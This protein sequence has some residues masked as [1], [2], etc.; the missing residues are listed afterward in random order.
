MVKQPQQQAPMPGQFFD[1]PGVPGGSTQWTEQDETTTN[2]LTTLQSGTQQTVQGILSF[3]QTDVV[4]DW[5]VALNIAQ[6][7][8]P[9]TSALAASAYAPF[10]VIG[11]VQLVIQNQYASV[12]VESGIDLYIFNI[13]RPHNLGEI[14]SGVNMG[15]NPGGFPVGGTALG[16]RAAA[17]AQ[18][19]NIPNNGTAAVWASTSTQ[20]NLLLRLPA[21]QWF[22]IY[23]DLLLTGEPNTAAHAALVSPQYMA[24]TTRNITPKITF[25]PGNAATLDQGPVNIGAGTGTYAGTAT[26]RFRRRAIYAGNE[27][28]QPPVYAW[29]YRW[30]TTRFGIGGKSKVDLPLPLDTGQLLLCYVRLFDPAAAAALG[31]PIALSTL[32]RINLQYGAGLFW[33]DAGNDGAITPAELIQRKWLSN[34][35]VMLPPGVWAFDLALDER[36]Q[37]SNKRALNTLTTAGILAH[38]DS[39]APVSSTSYATVGTESLVYVT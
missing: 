26:A 32:T 22:D 39:T 35:A 16:Y 11:A 14:L 31:A 6:T 34:H 33:W 1:V 20:Y 21:A 3:R 37:F 28:V 2:Q 18:P 10:N 9:G 19:N 7:Y 12:D 29:Q 4:T 13:A 23:Y 30:K 15:D 27:A 5:F 36:Q 25:A 38:F 17:L 8:T 24:G